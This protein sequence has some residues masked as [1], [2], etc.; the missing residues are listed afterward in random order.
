MANSAARGYIPKPPQ[1]CQQTLG[2]SGIANHHGLDSIT[3][4][5]PLSRQGLRVSGSAYGAMLFAPK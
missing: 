2:S 3:A 1:P 4:L 5:N